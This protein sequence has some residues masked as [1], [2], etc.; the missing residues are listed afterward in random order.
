MNE[1]KMI[2]YTNVHEELHNIEFLQ[3]VYYLIKEKE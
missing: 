1:L 3:D 2:R